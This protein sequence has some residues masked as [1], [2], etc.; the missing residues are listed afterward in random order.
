MDIAEEIN[1]G[2]DHAKV[3]VTIELDREKAIR[4]AISMAGKNDV[5]LICGKGADPFQKV[6]G[7]NTP[8]PSDIVVARN[9]IKE[10]EK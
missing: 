10:L 7:I 6:R 4:E 8:Y 5:V 3:D 1:A 2:I 9:V